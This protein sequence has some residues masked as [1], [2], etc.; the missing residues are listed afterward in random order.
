MIVL[1]PN[2]MLTFHEISKSLSSREFPTSHFM[3][4]SKSKA[5]FNVIGAVPPNVEIGTPRKIDKFTIGLDINTKFDIFSQFMSF[6]PIFLNEIICSWLG[7]Q[8][9]PVEMF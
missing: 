9:D 3:T 8:I 1:F 7:L 5:S 6:H 2:C 4:S